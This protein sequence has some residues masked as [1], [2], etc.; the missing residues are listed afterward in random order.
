MS[1]KSKVDVRVDSIGW[2]FTMMFPPSMIIAAK[3][4]GSVSLQNS[5]LVP[6]SPAIAKDGFLELDFVSDVPEIELD[7]RV[8]IWSAPFHCPTAEIQGV[9]V[10]GKDNRVE[11]SLT[12]N[13]PTIAMQN[14][15]QG[16][17]S[18][19]TQTLG[20][21]DAFPWPLG[22]LAGGPE[23]FP[24]KLT[25]LATDGDEP[26]NILDQQVKSLL[27]RNT[28][29]YREND[30]VTKDYRPDR[31]NIVLGA[32]TNKIVAIYMG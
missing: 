22:A 16:S 4:Y 30:M 13:D 27:G 17:N 11:K 3:G 26:Q 6:R 9:R 32:S 25:G 29:V 15:I 12:E 10:F 5:R 21:P 14:F 28:R 7:M 8:P 31:L 24:W 2:H 19:K 23:Y 1:L 18:S 20:G